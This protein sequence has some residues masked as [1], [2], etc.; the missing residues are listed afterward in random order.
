MRL[1]GLLLSVDEIDASARMQCDASG[2][3]VAMHFRFGV[4]QWAAETR[5]SAEDSPSTA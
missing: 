1:L 4:L 2:C 5:V 3:V